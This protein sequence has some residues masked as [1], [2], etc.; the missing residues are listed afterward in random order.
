M[1]P[2]QALCQSSAFGLSKTQAAA[3]PS[4][5]LEILVLNAIS[6]VW[7]AEAWIL[8]RSQWAWQSLEVEAFGA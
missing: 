7:W 1:I 6:L 4:Q 3:W 8:P 5:A 2:E